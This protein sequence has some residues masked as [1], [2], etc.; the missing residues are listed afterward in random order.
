MRWMLTL[1]EMT[2][3]PIMKIKEVHI[4]LKIYCSV[5]LWN[6][7]RAGELMGFVIS[8]G[9]GMHMCCGAVMQSGK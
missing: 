6:L 4:N 2:T 5:L 9:E 7:S 1:W 8:E 3:K